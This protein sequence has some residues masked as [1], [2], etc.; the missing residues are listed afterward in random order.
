VIDYLAGQK[1]RMNQKQ[2]ELVERLETMTE[3]DWIKEERERAT[4]LYLWLHME[5]GQSISHRDFELVKT[6]VLLNKPRPRSKRTHRACLQYWFDDLVIPALIASL[7]E[8]PR[9]VRPW[10]SLSSAFSF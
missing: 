2:I 10:R 3:N 5:P 4:K 9:E 1:H 6:G 8:V 7:W